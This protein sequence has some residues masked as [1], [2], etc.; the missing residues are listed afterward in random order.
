MHADQGR[1]LLAGQGHLLGRAVDCETFVEQAQA[2][3]VQVAL[4]AVADRHVDA[5]VLLQVHH[6]ALGI[7]AQADAGVP[8]IEAPQPRY[9]PQ[10]GKGRGGGNGQLG[11]AGCGPQRI[12][13]LGHFQKS[14]VQAVK[15]ALAGLGQA[16]LARQSFE[17]RHPQPVLQ[18]ADL[19]R[20]RGG[21]HRQVLGGG[22]ETQQARGGLESAQGGEGQVGEHRV[23]HG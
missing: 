7:Q 23:L 11:I 20:H 22:L 6:L 13:T 1:R 21:R 5:G 4:L 16:H 17:Q 12:D 2:V 14:T 15:Q 18:A 10:G 19:V 9:Q 3:Q 8:G